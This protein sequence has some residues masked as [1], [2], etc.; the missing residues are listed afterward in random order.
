[1]DANAL[2][3][4]ATPSGQVL[5]HTLTRLKGLHRRRR[6]QRVAGL[7]VAGTPVKLT[8]GQFALLAGTSPARINQTLNGNRPKRAP[9]PALSDLEVLLL[10]VAKP[11][12]ASSGGRRRSSGPRSRSSIGYSACTSKSTGARSR[13]GAVAAVPHLCSNWRCGRSTSSSRRS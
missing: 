1:M 12:F 10:D 7:V 9:A 3:V 11:L 2:N 13:R 6:D 8:L 4:S 5:G